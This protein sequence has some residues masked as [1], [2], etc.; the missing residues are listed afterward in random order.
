FMDSM[1]HIYRANRVP[2]EASSS[3]KYYLNDRI[4]T[5][6]QDSSQIMDD[7]GYNSQLASLNSSLNNDN[8]SSARTNTISKVDETQESSTNTPYSYIDKQY[9]SRWYH[10][11]YKCSASLNQFKPINNN[12]DE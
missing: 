3:N 4:D 8:N 6:H 11:K 10:E 5:S 1:N 2:I 12:D 9:F 7:T